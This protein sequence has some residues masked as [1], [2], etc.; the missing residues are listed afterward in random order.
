MGNINTRTSE[1]IQ[2]ITRK[3]NIYE[4]YVKGILDC[5]FALIIL[6][7]SLPLILISCLLIKIDSKGPVIFTQIRVGKDCKRFKL[8]KMRTM[9][10]NT[11]DDS[12]R[13]LDDKER[14]TRVGKVLRKLSLDELP[15]MVNILKREMSFIGPRPLLIRY[16]PYYTDEEIE[17]HRV[18]PGIT[19]LAQINGRSNLQWEDR[20]KYDIEYVNNISFVLDMK[21]LYKTILKVIKGDD[22]ST[23]R[24]D[25]LVDLDE[26]R[27]F[28][29]FR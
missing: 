26:H 29:S 2:Y 20:F 5:L 16:L 12:G 6:I 18:L 14:V 25:Y 10:L 24:P 23:V 3:Q 7:L 11:H 27:N 22:T 13:K 8:Y 19:G 28:K 4:N 21:I 9:K 17:R 1:K 15:Q